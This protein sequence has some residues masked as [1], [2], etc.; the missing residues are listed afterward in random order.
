[1]KENTQKQQDDLI[2]A[3]EMFNQAEEIR[4][5]G[6]IVADEIADLAKQKYLNRVEKQA[7]MFDRAGAKLIKRN[8][9]Q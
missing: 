2:S 9:Q 1:M 3:E 6:E 5:E 7:S 8:Q 4:R